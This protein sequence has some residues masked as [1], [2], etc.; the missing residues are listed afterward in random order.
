MINE[1][2][3]LLKASEALLAQ[4]E[5]DFKFKSDRTHFFS[6]LK[7]LLDQRKSTI[8]SYE[9]AKI[10]VSKEKITFNEKEEELAKQLVDLDKRITS[11][12]DQ[13][14]AELQ[15]ERRT[16]FQKG[17]SIT[18]YRIPYLGPTRD[19]IFFDRRK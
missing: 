14:M 4:L 11:L 3:M 19:G 18:K 16:V 17:K 2:Q 7:R 13:R 12:L 8:D 5:E 6:D 9:W 15:Q 10:K 1:M